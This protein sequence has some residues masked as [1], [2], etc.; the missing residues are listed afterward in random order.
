MF[1]SSVISKSG[2]MW[3]CNLALLVMAPGSLLII[4][5]VVSWSL[6]VFLSGILLGV[7]GLLFTCFALKCPACKARWY[8]MAI[9][10]QAAGKW[11]RW[12]FLQTECPRCKYGGRTDVA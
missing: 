11:A 8:W 3:K 12:L 10:S 4:V 1:P 7:C 5:G 6:Y 2:Q 9:S